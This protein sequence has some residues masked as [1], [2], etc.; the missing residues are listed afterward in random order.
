MAHGVLPK[1]PRSAVLIV[2]ESGTGKELVAHAI[3]EC[4]AQRG[5]FVPINCAA[6]PRDLV[7]ANCSVGSTHEIPGDIRLVASTNRDSAE[8]HRTGQLRT[9]LYYRLQVAAGGF[10]WPRFRTPLLSRRKLCVASPGVHY[11]GG[12]IVQSNG[13][14]STEC[15]GRFGRVGKF[16]DVAGPIVHLQRRH[17]FGGDVY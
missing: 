16:A 5:S 13:G 15:K 8:A 7:E 17:R 14:G 11:P 3:H 10:R 1:G 9:D 2:G 4:G 6:I 12:Q